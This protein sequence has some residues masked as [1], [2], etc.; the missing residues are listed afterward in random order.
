[1]LLDAKFTCDVVV[2]RS[3]VKNIRACYWTLRLQNQTGTC[4]ITMMGCM[5]GVGGAWCYPEGVANVLSQYIMDT[6]NRRCIPFRT[7]IFQITGQ[8]KDLC[9]NAVTKEGASCN[10]VPIPEGLHAFDVDRKTDGRVFGN[11][12]I[13]NKTKGGR[14]AIS[15]E[16]ETKMRRTH[17]ERRQ[18]S[19][20]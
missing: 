10:F 15:R 9:Y 7:G 6:F 2:N 17:L 13:D 3:V 4:R 1:M 20:Q 14:C 16:V 19:L 5:P 11:D 18:H 12:I 8:V